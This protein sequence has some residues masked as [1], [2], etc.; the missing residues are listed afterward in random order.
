MLLATLFGTQPFLKKLFADPPIKGHNLTERS[1]K[2]CLASKPKSS[3]APIKSKD[4]WCYP[5][6]GSSSARLLGSPAVEGSP[7]IGKTSTAR[8]SHSYASLQS[9]SCSENSVILYDVLGQTLSRHD[10]AAGR[11]LPRESGGGGPR[12]GGGGAAMR[13]PRRL[14]TTS[15]GHDAP[16]PPPTAVPLPRCAGE[17]SPPRRRPHPRLLRTA[18][19]HKVAPDLIGVTLLV[20]GVGGIIVEV[21]AYHHTDPAAHRYRGKTPRNAVIVRAARPGLCVPLLRHP[22]VHELR[23]RGGKAR[24]APY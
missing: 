17:E 13:R 9:A 22:L 11:F 18:S 3:N 20:D 23:L 12:S 19:V 1:R 5:S 7:R 6:A 10:N 15:A 21:E 4:L 16:P 2:S 24:R 8:G 14:K